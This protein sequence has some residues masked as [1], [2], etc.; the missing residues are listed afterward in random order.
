M[1]TNAQC[2]TCGKPIHV[3]ELRQGRKKYCSKQCKSEA[4][5][6]RVT[7]SCE[8]CGKEFEAPG[9]RSDR[10]YCSRQCYFR[11]RTSLT[12][13]GKRRC[14]TC[15]SVFPATPEY[16]GRQSN[17]KLGLTSQ[18]KQCLSKRNKK[19]KSSRKQLDKELLNEYRKKN[20]ERVRQW[21]RKSYLRNRETVIQKSREYRQ[22]NPD[23][24]KPTTEQ[25]RVK[26]A[27]KRARKKSF[28]GRYSKQDVADKLVSQAGKCFYCSTELTDYHVDHY[29]PLSRGGTNWPDNIVLAC[30]E[31]NLAK[32]NMMPQEFIESYLPI[33]IKLRV[34]RPTQRKDK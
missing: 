30:P 26:S 20:P 10:K 32:G 14:S 28:V 12:Q 15:Q 29:I 5:K 13:D 1:Q 19:L 11:S 27:M 25:Q 34:S 23:K 17:T 24:V 31:C 9:S 2:L 4:N 18:C 8:S 22:L 7:L 6:R 21:K 16:F 3:S 33:S